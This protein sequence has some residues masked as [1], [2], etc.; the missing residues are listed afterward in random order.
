[1]KPGRANLKQPSVSQKRVTLLISIVLISIFSIYLF[2][3]RIPS[4][5][6]IGNHGRVAIKTL[7]EVRRPF[8]DIHKARTAQRNISES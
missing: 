8:L 7:D 6:A 2:A 4:R 1:M 5:I 3:S